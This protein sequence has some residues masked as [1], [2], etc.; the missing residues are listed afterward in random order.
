MEL[1]FDRMERDNLF[2]STEARNFCVNVEGSKLYVPRGALALYSPVFERML[3][4]DFKEANA[5]SVDLK[6]KK[7]NDVLELFQVLFP[8]PVRKPVDDNNVDTMLSF[9]DEYD[10]DDLKNSCR[11]AL[12]QQITNL[13]LGDVEVF[14]I[15]QKA[16]KKFWFTDVIKKC[17]PYICCLSDDCLK[18]YKSLLPSKVTAAVYEAKYNRFKVQ[19]DHKMKLQEDFSNYYCRVCSTIACQ[20]CYINNGGLRI[21]HGNLHEDDCLYKHCDDEIDGSTRCLCGFVFND[22]VFEE[23]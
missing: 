13:S 20:E 9:A 12:L 14:K 7:L 2:H 16:S 15:I 21:C 17:I 8:L 23:I 1:T 11:Q 10:I 6:E 22:S 3:Y 4:G 18:Q 19:T 5:N